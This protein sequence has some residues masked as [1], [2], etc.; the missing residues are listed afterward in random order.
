[1]QRCFAHYELHTAA[2]AAV[3]GRITVL[4]TSRALENATMAN[5][6]LA[7]LRRTFGHEVRQQI[8]PGCPS[9]AHFARPA[10]VRACAAVVCDVL[11]APSKAAVP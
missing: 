11:A 3:T 4:L 8:M 6:D 2:A 1:V 5:R 9:H 7:L 10:G